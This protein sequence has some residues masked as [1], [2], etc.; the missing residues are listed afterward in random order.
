[1]YNNLQYFFYLKINFSFTHA[2]SDMFVLLPL[3]ANERFFI[4]DYKEFL[5]FHYGSFFT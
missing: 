3:L 5:A 4:F 2:L 1:M